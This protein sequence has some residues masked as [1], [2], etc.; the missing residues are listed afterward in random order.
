MFKRSV[1]CELKLEFVL[2]PLNST[3]IVALSSRTENS[4]SENVWGRISKI[5]TILMIV[6]VAGKLCGLFLSVLLKIAFEK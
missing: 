5:K 4:L 1:I 2:S 3:K 6:L